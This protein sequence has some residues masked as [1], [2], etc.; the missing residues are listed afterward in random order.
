MVIGETAVSSNDVK[1]YQTTSL[2]VYPNPTH[3]IIQWGKAMQFEFASIYNLQGQLI[4]KAHL[5]GGST[6]DLSSFTTGAYLLL[7]KG[8]EGMQSVMVMKE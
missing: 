1:D 2:Q 7:L 3:G 5:N 4:S 8:N 6:A